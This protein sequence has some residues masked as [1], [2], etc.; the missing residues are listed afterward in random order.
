MTIQ[1][2]PNDTNQQSDQSHQSNLST[3]SGTAKIA[4]DDV[5]TGA[6]ALVSDQEIQMMTREDMLDTIRAAQQVRHSPVE[7]ERI[8]ELDDSALRRVMHLVRRWMR[9]HVNELSI[10]KGLTPYFHD[11]I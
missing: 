7:P 1:A 2:G 6:I 3:T 11:R 4:C 5:V 10:D 9:G 8:D